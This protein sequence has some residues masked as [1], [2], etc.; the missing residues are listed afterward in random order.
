M[1]I[2]FVVGI[3]AVFLFVIQPEL[4]ST[5]PWW[6]PYLA[7][8]IFGSVIAITMTIWLRSLRRQ[9][10]RGLRSIE[11]DEAAVHYQAVLS[12][13]LTSERMRHRWPWRIDSASFCETY[14]AQGLKHPLA[15]LY[16]MSLMNTPSEN[17]E[18]PR[19]VMGDTAMAIRPKRLKNVVKITWLAIFVFTSFALASLLF[20]S[21]ETDNLVQSL[22]SLVPLFFMSAFFTYLFWFAV[23]RK[24]VKLDRGCIEFSKRFRH[25]SLTNNEAIC[26]V[27]SM[28]G[29]V[30]LQW[31]RPG[32]KWPVHTLYFHDPDD[33]RITTILTLWTADPLPDNSG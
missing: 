11:K 28:F 16:G 33:P 26:I 1:M 3:A 12:L 7:A 22:I 4:L 25:R 14:K 2:G 6:K 5:P 18:L 21:N 32:R 27:Y 13:F 10:I 17:L 23:A 29:L 24:H 20:S 31:R 30:T 15:I 8:I 9:D 19:R